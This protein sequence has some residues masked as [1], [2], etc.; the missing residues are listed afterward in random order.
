MR[1]DAQHV[2]HLGLGVQGVEPSGGDER[3]EVT[4]GLGVVVGD[5]LD[6]SAIVLALP[7][8]STS[9]PQ[10]SRRPSVDTQNRPGMDTAKPAS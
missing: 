7:P 10:V 3:E 5:L 9:T 4:G 8:R 2:T 6:S 1:Q